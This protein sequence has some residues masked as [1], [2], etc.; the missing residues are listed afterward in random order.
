M[1]LPRARESVTRP[2][3][4]MTDAEMA[5]RIDARHD[6]LVR[7]TED[8]LATETLEG[9]EARREEFWDRDYASIEA[10]RE[11]VAPARERWSEVIGAFGPA[12]A[13]P[14]PVT[15]PF[16]ETDA[17]RAERLSLGLLEGYR[18]RGQAILGRPTGEGPHPLVLCLHGAGSSPERTF[19]FDDPDRHY[20]AF[21]RR[22]L[23]AGYAVLA[24]RA[25]NGGG[26]RD[27]SER[28]AEWLGKTVFGLERR[29]V[30][31]FLDHLAGDPTIDTDR[32]GAWGLSMGGTSALF[33]APVEPRIDAAICSGF[34]NRRPKINVGDDPRYGDFW[35]AASNVHFGVPG[36]LRA[37]SDADLVSLICPRPFMAQMGAADSIAWIPDVRR[38]F[39]DARE[40]YER[41]GIDDRI[42]L[43]VHEGG[44]EIRVESG[45]G[46][47]DRHL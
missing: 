29:C 10:Y 39:D 25:I 12:A 11:S 13:D 21:A 3:D 43:D 24:P 26:P 16:L 7:E 28:L 40:H 19:G 47:L 35:P 46:F 44:H 41:L 18:L 2:A 37:F 34:F 14:A 45:I 15:E 20:D 8:Y 32:V 38:E 33:L 42:A 5:R 23:E 31:A 17:F 9:Y 30:G 27:R 4:E 6:R 1:C 22:L 36:W